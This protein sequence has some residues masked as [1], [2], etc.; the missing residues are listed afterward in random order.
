PL[1]S[2]DPRRRAQDGDERHDGEH[3]SLPDSLAEPRRAQGDE[4]EGERVEVVLPAFPLEPVME[5]AAPDAA[6]AQGQ[7]GT[8]DHLPARTWAARARG[9]RGPADAAA[10]PRREDDGAE[11]APRPEPGEERDAKILARDGRQRRD[12]S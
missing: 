8:D 6:Q 1:A 3:A 9:A 7:R 11:R 12:P 5:N 4:E 10:R 2:Q